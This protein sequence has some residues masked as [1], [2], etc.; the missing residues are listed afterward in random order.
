[1]RTF[2]KVDLVDADSI[3][4]SSFIDLCVV[5]L[6]ESVPCLACALVSCCVSSMCVSDP[7]STTSYPPGMAWLIAWL[8]DVFL[9]PL[10]SLGT[11]TTTTMSSLPQQKKMVE[12][13]RVEASMQRKLV[14]DCLKDMMNFI[15]ERQGTDALVMG[16][17]NKKDNPFMEKGGCTVL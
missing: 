14:S 15:Q 11:T 17:V 5:S 1:M 2:L 4:E 9:F 13:L 16:F 10:P 7:N 8:M 12:Q 6:C 3:S